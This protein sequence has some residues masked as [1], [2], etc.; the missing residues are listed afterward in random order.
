MD[1]TFGKHNEDHSIN[2][3]STP[4]TTIFLSSNVSAS[5]LFDEVIQDEEEAKYS[6]QS[7]QIIESLLGVTPSPIALEVYE[8]FDISYSHKDDI[9]EEI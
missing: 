1:K 4:N 7:I 9:E 2:L 5:I 8:I 6:T 3:E